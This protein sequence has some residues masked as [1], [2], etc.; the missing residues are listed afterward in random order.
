MTKLS[1]K[2]LGAAAVS[3]MVAAPAFA[4][5]QASVA[6]APTPSAVAAAIQASAGAGVVVTQNTAGNY[7]VSTAGG[8]VIGT[9]SS[10]IVAFY[11]N[12]YN[13]NN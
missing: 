4:G 12:A 7:V 10:Q 8:A 1:T 13:T 2:I 9:F 6:N 5:K 3:L 11:L